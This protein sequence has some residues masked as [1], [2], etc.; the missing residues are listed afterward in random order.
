MV[1]AGAARSSWQMAQSRALWLRMDG[2]ASTLGPVPLGDLDGSDT[3]SV[4]T[5]F[6]QY[7]SPPPTPRVLPSTGAAESTPIHSG[8]VPPEGTVCGYIMCYA[9][10]HLKTR[11]LTLV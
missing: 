6:A 3:R 11:N 4:R 10:R 7:S 9:P 5:L 1:A 8:N 2:Q